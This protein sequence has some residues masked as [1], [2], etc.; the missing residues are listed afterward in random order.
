[1]PA[2]SAAGWGP[3]PAPRRT[4][5]RLSSPQPA[6]AACRAAP[7]PSCTTPR[8]PASRPLPAP[9]G[10]VPSDA[11][12]RPPEADTAPTAA[13]AVLLQ[14]VSCT[15]AGAG[16][17]SA[18]STGDG[19]P[20][21][22]SRQ[23]TVAPRAGVEVEVGR[24]RRARVSSGSAPPPGSAAV[25]GALQDGGR[26][27][28]PCRAPRCEV[29]QAALRVRVRVMMSGGGRSDGRGSGGCSG[30]GDGGRDG[31]GGGESGSRVN[32]T[33]HHRGRRRGGETNLT[34]AA[35]VARTPL[36][37]A[38]R[39]LRHHLWQGRTSPVVEWAGT[40]ARLSHLQTPGPL[41]VRAQRSA[42]ARLASPARRPVRSC[43]AALAV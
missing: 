42:A 11:A 6:Y 14:P 41:S 36:L 13:G 20:V 34:T 30:G 37:S 23:G 9:A 15:E 10:P 8:C 26:R 7:L 27:P 19:R 28:A 16:V 24:R 33:S 31:G 12:Q 38:A 3:S 29:R 18:S 25:I 1:M 39:A 17:G 4:R 35:A 43:R 21:A 2:S 22:S 32:L 40:S 5:S